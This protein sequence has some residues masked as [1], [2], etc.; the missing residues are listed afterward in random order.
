MKTAFSK[1]DIFA[2]VHDMF[3]RLVRWFDD[4]FPPS[5]NLFLV[6]KGAISAL[7]KQGHTKPCQCDNPVCKRKLHKLKDNLSFYKDLSRELN[8]VCTV[9][10]RE[11]RRLK[12]DEHRRAMMKKMRRNSI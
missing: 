11:V 8:K 5:P 4:I 12:Y 6:S 9:L 7:Q 1:E 10:K 3:T 2:F